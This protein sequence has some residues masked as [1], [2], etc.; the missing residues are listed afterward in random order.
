MLRLGSRASVAARA[1]SRRWL[2]ADAAANV[3]RG[4]SMPTAEELVEQA[5]AIPSLPMH[6]TYRKSINI[7]GTRNSGWA[8]AKPKIMTP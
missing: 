3:V 2:S 8:Q 5:L 7:H 6:N 4:D 1:G